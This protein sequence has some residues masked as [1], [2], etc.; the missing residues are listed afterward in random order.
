MINSPQIMPGR[1]R[2]GGGEEGFGEKM[3]PHGE[4][5]GGRTFNQDK[6]D[7]G[8]EPTKGETSFGV[9]KTFNECQLQ[10]KI[11]TFFFEDFRNVEINLS[12]KSIPIENLLDYKYYI[13]SKF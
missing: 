7:S 4:M 1:G 8:L 11:V 13:I 10:Q 9:I 6:T 12:E 2:C 5:S 3:S